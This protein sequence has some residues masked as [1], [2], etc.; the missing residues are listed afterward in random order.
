[1]VQREKSRP[2]EKKTRKR[3]K[4]NLKISN[5][6]K[7]TL[8]NPG[9]LGFQ[10][11]VCRLRTHPTLGKRGFGF[12]YQEKTKGEEKQKTKKRRAVVGGVERQEI[13]PLKNQRDAKV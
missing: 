8:Q 9:R 10:C 5:R 3:T 7:D 11:V 6:V 1:M 12:T 2:L 13:G 4:D